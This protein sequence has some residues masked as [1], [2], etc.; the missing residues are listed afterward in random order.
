M[1]NISKI[2]LA[3]IREYICSIPVP[4][5]CPEDI[6]PISVPVPMSGATVPLYARLIQDRKRRKRKQIDREDKNYKDQ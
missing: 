5:L 3:N 6:V 2:P 1:Q 4:I